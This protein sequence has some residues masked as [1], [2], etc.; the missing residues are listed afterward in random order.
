MLQTGRVAWPGDGPIGGE[1]ASSAATSEA[2]AVFGLSGFQAVIPSAYTDIVGVRY[3]VLVRR[4]QSASL[5]LI[6]GVNR[7]MGPGST[8][9][10][11]LE[12][13]VYS[14]RLTYSDGGCTT[15]P[16]LGTYREA[17]AS[18]RL[19]IPDYN[20]HFGLTPGITTGILTRE[21]VGYPV[22]TYLIDNI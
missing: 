5:R 9:T 4:N 1:V 19:A 16:L 11:L 20:Y 17:E 13:N 3:W 6:F 2:N 18:L 21:P 7:L 8:T 22:Q 14:S 10:Y 15:W 12:S